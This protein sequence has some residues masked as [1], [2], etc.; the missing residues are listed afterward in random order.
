MPGQQVV[1]NGSPP[2]LPPEMTQRLA[3]KTGLNM[4][5]SLAGT[6]AH[7]LSSC[8]A[9]ERA[10]RATRLYRSLSCL[11]SSYSCGICSFTCSYVRPSHVPAC[12]WGQA[13][14]RGVVGAASS[15]SDGAVS[16]RHPTIPAIHPK[17]AR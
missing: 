13:G 3:V 12:G 17:Q 14:G 16:K 6:Y 2:G 10:A 8:T 5:S 7:R 1:Q 4:P 11:R 15:A 9:Q